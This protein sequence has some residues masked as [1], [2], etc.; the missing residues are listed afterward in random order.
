MVQV[1]DPWMSARTHLRTATAA[2][3]RQ[4]EQ[5]PVAKLLAKGQIERVTYVDYLRAIAV[6]VANLRTA[7]ARHGTPDLRRLLP[8]LE[9]WVGRID[10]DLDLLASDDGM[11]NRHAQSAALRRSKP[12]LTGRLRRLNVSA[13]C[14]PGWNTATTGR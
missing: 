10:A 12:R 9:D 2:I 8:T 6:M 13:R 7:I 14:L 4:L 11:A 1:Y 5:A 3:H